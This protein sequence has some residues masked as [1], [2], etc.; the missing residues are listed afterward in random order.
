L[1]GHHPNYEMHLILKHNKTRS[2]QKYS[3][4]N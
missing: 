1:N 4:A 3:F 2:F